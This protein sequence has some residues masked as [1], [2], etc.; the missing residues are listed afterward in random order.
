MNNTHSTLSN[1]TAQHRHTRSL[2][3]R[4]LTSVHHWWYWWTA[5]WISE[6]HWRWTL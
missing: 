6:S 3:W 5:W 4:S 2:S 1:S